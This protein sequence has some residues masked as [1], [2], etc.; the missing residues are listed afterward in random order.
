MGHADY[1][2]IEVVGEG[3]F[4]V[5]TRARVIKTGQE[6]AIKK[7]RKPSGKN[8]ADLSTLRETMLLAELRHQ[9]VI[10]LK[11][12]YSHNSALSLVFEFCVTDLEKASAAHLSDAAH[13]SASSA[14]SAPPGRDTVGPGS[15][16]GSGSG[17]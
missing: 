14:L 13:T 17:R 9:H 5:V 3:T 8:G 7:I 11:E 16:S 4:G 12:A 2:K 10:E 1:E 6:V 15:G